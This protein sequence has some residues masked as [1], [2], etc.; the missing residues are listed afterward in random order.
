MKDH[1]PGTY[2]IGWHSSEIECPHVAF[3]IESG[4]REELF[5][6]RLYSMDEGNDQDAAYEESKEALELLVRR[7]N[8]ALTARAIRFVADF[9]PIL[10]ANGLDPESVSAYEWSKFTDAFLEGT[11]WH[12]IAGYACDAIKIMREE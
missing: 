5:D 4:G 7:A 2:E 8:E 12:E 6:I 9:D 11:H 10:V 1:W 3:A